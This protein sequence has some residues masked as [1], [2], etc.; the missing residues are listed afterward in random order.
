MVTISLLAISFTVPT[1]S[2]AT[3]SYL[4]TSVS[5]SG[6][7]QKTINISNG[8]LVNYTSTYSSSLVA[9]V[10][11]DLANSAGQTI[12]WNVASCTFAANQMVQCFVIIASTVPKGI[13]TASVFATTTSS[14]PLSTTSSVQV[15]I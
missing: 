13:Y 10:Y 15:T 9:F 12:Y 5:Q 3:N 14:V 8:V 11:L 2:G 4:T 6:I 7:E 1:A